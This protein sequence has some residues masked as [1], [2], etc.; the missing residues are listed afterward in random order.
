MGGARYEKLPPGEYFV[1]PMT[2]GSQLGVSFP[3]I[4]KIDQGKRNKLIRLFHA[5][6]WTLY[7]TY[8]R[9]GFSQILR[10][11]YYLAI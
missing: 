8:S 7:L 11:F 6:N 3:Y 10:E 2:T 1:L 5:L 9:A 4:V